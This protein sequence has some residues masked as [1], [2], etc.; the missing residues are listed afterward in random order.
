MTH[1]YMRETFLDLLAQ[2]DVYAWPI[3]LA[4]VALDSSSSKWLICLLFAAVLCAIV[5][6]LVLNFVDRRR[7]GA[8]YACVRQW[9]GTGG[10][11]AAAG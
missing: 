6:K 5:H 11:A 10:M 9:L 3:Y 1:E 2:P 8:Q 7:A 4:F